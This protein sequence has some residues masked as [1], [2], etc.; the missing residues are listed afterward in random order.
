MSFKDGGRLV[1]FNGLTG[2]MDASTDEV[3]D[4]R[5]QLDR[6]IAAASHVR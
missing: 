2:A 4:L 3:I 1:Y 5:A 6:A